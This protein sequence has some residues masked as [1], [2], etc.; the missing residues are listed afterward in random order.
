MANGEVHV[1]DGMGSLVSKLDIQCLANMASQ[2]LALI[3][4]FKIAVDRKTPL[5]VISY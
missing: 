1:Y 5:K 4:P 2:V 3:F